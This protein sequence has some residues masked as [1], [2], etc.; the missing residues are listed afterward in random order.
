MHE[1]T[2]FRKLGP[3]VSGSV[4]GDDDFGNNYNNDNADRG[5]LHAYHDCCMF[6]LLQSCCV[7]VFDAYLWASATAGSEHVV[8]P[9]QTILGI[10]NLS[11]LPLPAAF[12]EL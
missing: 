12:W 10:L 5:N 3:F 6:G 9:L 11:R 7:Q 2:G 1:A 8:E 4:G